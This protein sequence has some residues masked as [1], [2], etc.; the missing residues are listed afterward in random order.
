[1]IF[2]DRK[3]FQ[4]SGFSVQRFKGSKVKDFGF[5]VID[6]DAAGIMGEL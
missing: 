6:V 2:H 1:L 4:G 3:R 5:S